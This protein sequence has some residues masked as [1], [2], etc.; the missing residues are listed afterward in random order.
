MLA[1]SW[2]S[3]GLG[4]PAANR[5]K[6]RAARGLTRQALTTQDYE[7]LRK[8]VA[9]QRQIIFDLHATEKLRP[10][11]LEPKNLGPKC[12]YGIERRENAACHLRAFVQDSSCSEECG[13]HFRVSGSGCCLCALHVVTQ[14]PILD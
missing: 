11:V 4:P 2:R 3:H 9:K 1:S 7:N 5:R 14:R 10:W 8:A 6:P 12:L 13:V